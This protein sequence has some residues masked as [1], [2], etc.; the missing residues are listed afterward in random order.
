MV[1]HGPKGR[2]NLT[3]G[4]YFF[5]NHYAIVDCHQLITIGDG[6]MVGPSAY[7]T[8]FDHDISLKTPAVS[9]VGR[10]VCSPVSIGNNVWIGA[11]AV[12]LK[13][14]HIGDGAVVAAG[15]VVTKDVPALAV[16]GGIPARVLKMRGANGA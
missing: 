6:V 11:N 9:G 5:L 14:V 16:V 4:D 8:D 12:V 13:G 7:I 10:K 1:Q 3:I 2:G 15:A